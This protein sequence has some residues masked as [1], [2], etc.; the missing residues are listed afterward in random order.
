MRAMSA[1]LVTVLV[2][3]AGNNAL[4][5]STASESLKTAPQAYHV[6]YI[7]TQIDGAKRVGVQHYT[8]SVTADDENADLR[9]GSRVPI[10]VGSTESANPALS[11]QIQYLDIGLDITAKLLA[12]SN[13]LELYSHVDQSS[14]ANPSGTLLHQPVIRHSNLTNTTLLIPGTI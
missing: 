7:L 6:T 5:Q 10:E 4:A 14:V 8:M 1:V 9:L 12:F 2:L 11:T 13:G 3:A